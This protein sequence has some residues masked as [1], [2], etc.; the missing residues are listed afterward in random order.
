MKKCSFCGTDNAD[1]EVFCGLCGYR[2]VTVVEEPIDE[3]VVVH[4][5]KPVNEVASGEVSKDLSEQEVETV[6]PVVNSGVNDYYSEPTYTTSQQDVF[7]EYKRRSNNNLI[8][9]ILFAIAALIAVIVI[10]TTSGNKDDDRGFVAKNSIDIV[11][12]DF[13]IA[14][15]QTAEL[16]ID[17]SVSRLNANYNDCI[18]TYWSNDKTSGDNYY[19][20]VT[21]VEEGTCYLKVHDY[22]NADLYDTVTIYV[23]SSG[24]D[25]TTGDGTGE[26]VEP[27][28]VVKQTLDVPA[29]SVSTLS[30]DPVLPN[31]YSAEVATIISYS[32]SITYD[33]QKDIYYFEAPYE[34]RY[35]MDISGLQSGT[36]VELYI[37]DSSGKSIASDT[38][39]KNDEGITAKSLNANETYEVQVRHTSGYSDYK[40]SIG[41]QK[42]TVDISGLT[43]LTD[44]IEYTDQRNVYI[45]TAPLDGRYRFELSGMMSG[46]ATELYVFS[47][48][49]ETVVSDTYCKNG[50]GVTAKGLV[51][52][53]T[54]SVQVRYASGFSGYGLLIGQQKET[55]NIED[56]VIVNDSIEYTDQRN[57]YS[58]KATTSGDITISLCEMTNGC[59]V[60]LLVFNELEETVASDTYCKNGE[61]VTLK[62]ANIG[63]HYE[64]QVRYSSG[65]SKYQLTIN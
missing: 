4:E 17:S 59:A 10:A 57:V 31:I 30:I 15:G 65:I 35:R 8:I 26:G 43:Q 16:R 49:G 13:T 25:I 5:D 60:E 54:Y 7:S 40:L 55:V 41:L 6:V 56:Y 3:P 11:A 34:G 9:I 52:G 61:G 29:I 28:V 24:E 22:N 21:G 1:G 12:E 42:A 2:F 36:A 51:A 58:F 14:V 64:I 37:F 48:L 38:Y 45:F 20:E 47:S 27:P 46:T 33:K 53:E 44:S 23:V 50:E 39:C 32:G 19:L 63:T 62:N 18:D